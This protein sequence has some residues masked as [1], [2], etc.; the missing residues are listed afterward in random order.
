MGMVK[1]YAGG[2]VVGTMALCALGAPQL[3][4]TLNGKAQTGAG[5]GAGITVRH[6]NDSLVPG[7]DQGYGGTY[8]KG[9]S[10]AAPQAQTG[11]PAAVAAPGQ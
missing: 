3:A 6:L 4:D 1:K 7:F 10:P 2:A 5:Q 11:G 8:G 9:T